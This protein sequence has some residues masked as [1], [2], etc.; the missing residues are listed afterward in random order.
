TI[1][2][3]A[4]EQALGRA[5]EPRAD[6]YSLGAMLYE[7]VT[8]QPPFAGD[9]ALAIITQHLRTPPVAPAWRNPEVSKPLDGLIV[10]LLAKDPRDRPQ[11]AAEVREAL[12]ALAA[13]A[14]PVPRRPSTVEVE[15][16]PLDRL[17]GG[18]H[19][20]RER[21]VDELCDAA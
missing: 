5:P 13:L 4:P 16:N 9:D 8:G 12:A 2:Y 21:E 19:V 14:A 11:S 18:V 3:I 17:A 1:D 15:G 7:L 6:L 20:G 10:R